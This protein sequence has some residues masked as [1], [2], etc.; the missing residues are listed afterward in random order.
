MSAVKYLLHNYGPC[1]RCQGFGDDFRAVRD[2]G[3]YQKEY[4][5][6]LV[7]RWDHLIDWAERSRNEGRF[8]A[9]ELRKG[10]AVSVL[11][12]AAGTGA[13]SI[14]LLK[15]GFR[16]TSL[17]GHAGMLAKA[18]Q[19]AKRCGARLHLM[20]EDWRFLGAALQRRYDAV[21]CL[22]NSIAHLFSSRDRLAAL[23]GFHRCLKPRGKLFVDHLDSERLGMTGVFKGHRRYYTG[24]GVTVTL[25]YADDGLLRFAYRFPLGWTFFLHFAPLQ[26]KPFTELL[27]AAGFQA[28]HRYADCSP[29]KGASRSEFILYRAEKR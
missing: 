18:R 21:I 5:H 2:S 25:A 11:D 3:H 24:A 20:R 28:I 7:E 4:V 16:V 26:Q 13:D 12:A 23:S 14:Q 9:D 1:S 6:A 19:N 17:D 15:A 27:S 8:I 29:A 10:G 22:G